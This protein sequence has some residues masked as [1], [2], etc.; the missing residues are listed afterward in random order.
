MKSEINVR[1]QNCLFFEDLIHPEE[2]FTCKLSGYM[3]YSK[4]CGNFC[5]NTNSLSIISCQDKDILA[6]IRKIP[7]NKLSEVAALIVQEGYNREKNWSIGDIAYFNLGKTDYIDSYVQIVFKGLAG[8]MNLALIEGIKDNQCLWFGL[9][10]LD[11]L[12]KETDWR[13]KHKELKRSGKLKNNSLKL[14]FPGYT[15]KGED[16][17][18]KD[19]YCPNNIVDYLKK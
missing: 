4:P 1:C 11:S 18:E 10:E 12:L 15:E 2:N 19:S 3:N 13:E 7:T 6:Y 5:V 9:V 8:N 14:I 16:E 17:L